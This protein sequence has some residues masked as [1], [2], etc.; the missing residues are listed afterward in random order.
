M[1]AETSAN[2]VMHEIMETELHIPAVRLLIARTFA[3]HG[4]IAVASNIVET[5]N[6]IQLWN[7]SI[8]NEP[9]IGNCREFFFSP[10]ILYLKCLR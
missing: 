2:E 10:Y 7:S 8:E 1:A 6:R 9:D 5:T 4:S 3:A